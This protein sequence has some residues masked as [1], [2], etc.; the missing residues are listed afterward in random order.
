ML[1]LGAACSGNICRRRAFF[2]LRD[3]GLNEQPPTRTMGPPELA[4][5]QRLAV[6]PRNNMPANS[7]KLNKANHGKRPRNHKARRTKRFK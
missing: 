5:L 3:R 6:E 1:R 7:R 2:C 4:C